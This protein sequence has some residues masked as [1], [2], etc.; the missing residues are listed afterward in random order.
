L[1]PL[2]EKKIISNNIYY[3]TMDPVTHL[4]AGAIGAQAIR[5]S[6]RD[7][8]LLVF[9]I[10]AAWLPDI[11]NFIGFLGMEFYLVHHRGLT[12]SFIG[13]VLLAAVFVGMFKLFA[14]SLSF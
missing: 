7:R 9:C 2:R 5:K 12:H 6:R 8:R 10:L 13:G 4:A 3:Q 1:A 11:D 14:R